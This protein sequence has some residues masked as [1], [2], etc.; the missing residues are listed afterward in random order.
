MS[1]YQMKQ[2]EKIKVFLY[3]ADEEVML[4]EGIENFLPLQFILKK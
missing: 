2:K 4:G 1:E 3:R